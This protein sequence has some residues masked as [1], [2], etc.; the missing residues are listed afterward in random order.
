MPGI[1]PS[2]QVS[3]VAA[4]G[5]P[6]PGYWAQAQHLKRYVSVPLIANG[7]LSQPAGGEKITKLRFN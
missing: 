4:H 7:V 5:H 1:D 2:R 3:M 6:S